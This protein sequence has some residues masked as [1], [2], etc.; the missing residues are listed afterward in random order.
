MSFIVMCDTLYVS[1]TKRQHELCSI[2]S[3]DLTFFVHTQH[4]CFIR[5]IQIKP[6][7]IPNLFYEERIGREL[8]MFFVCGVGDQRLA[9]LGA[10]WILKSSFPWQ[11]SDMSNGYHLSVSY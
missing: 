9:K 4:H 11:L 6:N 3:L 8:K 7:N 2:K 10:P 5:R 1:Q